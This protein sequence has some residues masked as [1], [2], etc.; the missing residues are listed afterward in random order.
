[1]VA[2]SQAR[3]LRRELCRRDAALTDL[4]DTFGEFLDVLRPLMDRFP[5]GCSEQARAR[6]AD[7]VHRAL[8]GSGE[9]AA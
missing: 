3:T 2:V 6:W 1:M 4:T 7:E 8:T 9:E 5:A